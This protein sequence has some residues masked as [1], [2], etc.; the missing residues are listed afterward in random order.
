M[1]VVL[2]N[3]NE[4]MRDLDGRLLPFG[5]LKLLWGLKVAYPK[6]VRVLLMGVRQRYQ[7]S[8]LGAALALMLIEAV[9]TCGLKRS[10]K[11]AE[12]SWILEDNMGMRN[13]IESIGGVAYKRYR[14]YGRDL[15]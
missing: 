4:V 9:R 11:E 5:W 12:L 3:L 7:N 15:K 14:I 8:L 10:I 13:I 2:P 1:I 6:T